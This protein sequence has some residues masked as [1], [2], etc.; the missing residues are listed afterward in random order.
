M[1]K[2]TGFK[3]KGFC[4]S[5]TIWNYAVANASLRSYIV[6]HDQSGLSRPNHKGSKE[7]NDAIY[8]KYVVDK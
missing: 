3:I 7:N 2:I 1:T 5:N 4:G 6:H 8:H